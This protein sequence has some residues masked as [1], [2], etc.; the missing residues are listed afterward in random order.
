MAVRGPPVSY[1]AQADEILIIET[2]GGG[3]WRPRLAVP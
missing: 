2:L 3:G 1:E